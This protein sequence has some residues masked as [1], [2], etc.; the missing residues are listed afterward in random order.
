MSLGIGIVAPEGIVLAAESRLTL[1]ANTAAGQTIVVN[2]DNASKVLAFSRPNQWVGAVTYGQAVIGFRTAGSFLPEFETGLSVTRLSVAAF[3]QAMSDFYL[4]QWNAV[5]PTPWPGGPMMFLVG[6][7]DD[8]QPYPC[9]YEFSIPAAPA[10]MQRQAPGE[11]G[12]TWGG[13]RE[14]VDR[15]VQ[16]FDA[17][18]PDLVQT[19][20]SL[21][22]AQRAQ[23][24]AALA[25]LQLP[26]PLQ[27]MP[28]QDC[29]DLAIF[30]IR[31][32]IAAQSLTIGIR[33][34][35]GPIDVA[36]VT[37]RDGLAFVQRKELHGE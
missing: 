4:A 17:N 36:T 18:L 7:Y 11:F 8:G 32:T 30:F 16:G 25:S 23:L 12:M 19:A 31:T 3:A 9:L 24:D 5:M 21:T 33:G 10:P 29:I 37:R 15:L 20:L 34:V 1:S 35:G 13:Q 26:L 27:A 14:H 2:Y 6:G 28:L 22:P